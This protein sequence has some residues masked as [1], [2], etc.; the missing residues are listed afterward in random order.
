MSNQAIVL[1][2]LIAAAVAAGGMLI[3]RAVYTTKHKGD[4]EALSVLTKA[5]A[6][7]AGTLWFVFLGWEAFSTFVLDEGITFTAGR[8]QIMVLILL[9][10]QCL[11]E[12]MGAYYYSKMAGKSYKEYGKQM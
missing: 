4:E 3:W 2:A 9:G 11:V 8:V 7:S 12:L 1:T 5:K 10:I 6:L